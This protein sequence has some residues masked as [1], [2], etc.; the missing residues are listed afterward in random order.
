[1]Y[2][3]LVGSDWSECLSP[4]GPFD[5]ISF[6]YPELAGEMEEIFR[7][8]TSNRITLQHAVSR[9]AAALPGAFTSAMM[10]RYLESSFRTYPGVSELIS[11][12][13]AN[14]I[15]FALNTTGTQGYFQRA[16]ALGLLPEIPFVCANPFITYSSGPDPRYTREIREI[17]DKAVHTAGLRAELGIP[18]DRVVVIGDSGGDGPHFAWAQS[19]GAYK[20]GSMTKRSL[21][22]FCAERVV[23]IDHYFGVRFFENPSDAPEPDFRLLKEVIGEIVLK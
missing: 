10:D 22:T 6:T 23:T 4:N 5:P 12:C 8:Y 11:W 19:V 13:G 15:A 16:M 3:G 17:E 1:M 14:D 20:I 2:K 7:S 21:H 9:I 18:A